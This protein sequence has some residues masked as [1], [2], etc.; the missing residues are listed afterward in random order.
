M[1]RIKNKPTIKELE[2]LLNSEEDDPIEIL[3]NGEIRAIKKSKNKKKLTVLT[4]GQVLGGEYAYDP[5]H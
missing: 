4:M 3:P 2:A 5:I 1:K